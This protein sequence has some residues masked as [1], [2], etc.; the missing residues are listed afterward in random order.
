M[1]PTKND[2]F[3]KRGMGHSKSAFARNFKFLS[4]FVLHVSLLSTYVRFI[5]EGNE[6]KEMK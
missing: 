3:L 1:T 2:R 5:G 6:R 4:L